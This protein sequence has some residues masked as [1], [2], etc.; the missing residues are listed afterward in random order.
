MKLL[1]TGANGHI[2]KSIVKNLSDKY[3]SVVGLTR[4]DI[5]LL[6]PCKV[7]EYFDGKYFDV[8][9]HCAVVGGRRVKKDGWEVLD[10]NLIMYYNLLNCKSHYGKLIHFGSGAEIYDEESPYGL[11]KFIIRKSVLNTSNFYNIRIYAVFDENE[12]DNR[13]IKANILNYIHKKPITV[14]QNRIMDFFYMKDLIKLVKYYIDNDN[15]PK[16]SDCSYET[17]QNLVQISN[18][19][20][21]LS[22]H[23]VEI[24]IEADGFMKEY[25]GKRVQVPI[26]FIGLKQGLIETYQNLI[27][28]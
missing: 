24:K 15:L 14:Y 2:G 20:N 9:I 17:N 28:K 21:E 3:D 5:D 12:L 4:S 18:M 11:S 19:I 6:D 26:E 8:V 22:S 13:F 1:V 10:Q 27:K 23:K 25:I 7:K 16:E